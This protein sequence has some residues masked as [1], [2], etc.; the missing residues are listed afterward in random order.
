MAITV[1]GPVMYD[2]AYSNVSTEGKY[3]AVRWTAHDAGRGLETF[4]DL[5]RAKNF[6]DYLNA[7]H[8]WSCPGQNFV[9]ASKSGDIAIKQQGAFIARWK[10]QGDFVMP[11]TDSSYAWQGI[12][13]NE[14]N[15]ML[16]N[17]P[18]GFVSSANQLV[19]DA[20]YPYYLGASNNFP[21]YR[22]IIINRM[23]SGMTNITAQDM[24]R[25]QMNNYNVLAETVRPILLRNIDEGALNADEKKYVG[26]LK[27]WNL[28]GD[29]A[30]NGATV[31][32]CIW[33]SLEQ[34][35]WGDEFKQNKLPMTWPDPSTLAESLAKDSVYG[36]ADD[37]STKNKVETIKDDVMMAVKKAAVNLHYL[38]NNGSLSWAKSKD[39]RVNHLLRLPALSRLHLPIG[40]GSNMINATK[41][42]HGPSWRM[43]VHLTDDIEAYGVYPGGQSGNP[44]S[45]YYDSFVDSW[46]AGRYYHLLFLKRADAA[47]HTQVKWHLSFSRT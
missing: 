38:E 4:Y 16:K 14:E 46:A 13:P 5:D 3:L 36:F 15:P 30:E 27:T 18:R 28:R 9:F 8:K 7:I 19:T 39:T 2:K 37:I 34:V 10:R 17:P 35:V 29:A 43:I 24:Q 33:D 23:L 42:N 12:I 31:F 22:G 40:G 21:L 47:K 20:S 32:K 25:L 45:R 44:G 6:D 11:G 1:F 26:M 41:E